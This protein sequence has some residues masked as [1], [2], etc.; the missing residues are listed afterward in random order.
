MYR[1]IMTVG[2]I[3]VNIEKLDIGLTPAELYDRLSLV[4][5]CSFLLES[6]V[7]SERTVSYSF[8]GF[9]PEYVVRCVKG[10]VEGG[11]D[12]GVARDD[13]IAY[14]NCLSSKDPINDS[15][16]PFL[17]GLVGYF[18][19]DFARF[20]EPSTRM[21]GASDF[22]D[23]E[24][25]MYRE[26]IIFDHSSFQAYYFSVD[27]A[28]R[29]KLLLAAGLPAAKDEP[30]R[31]GELV[32]T[33]SRERYE[34]VVSVCRERIAAGEAFQIVASRALSSKCSGNSL[35]LYR[36]LRELNPSPYMFYFDFDGRVVLGSSPETLVT[37]RKGEVI[38]FPIA[39]TRPLGIT[40]KEKRSYREEM[41]ADEKERAE[42]C[43]LVDLARNDVGKVCEIG[44][45]HV[46]VFMQVEEFSHVQHMVSKVQGTLEQGRTS[47]DAFCAVFPAGTVSGAP[48]PRAMEII[49]E[50][51]KSSR[52]PYAGAVGYISLNGNLDSAIAIRS[53]F[54]SNDHIYIQAGAGIVADSDPAKEYVEAEN[55]LKAVKKAIEAC[56]GRATA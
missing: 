54:I 4:S 42:H 21:T 41:L 52:G 30:F 20:I 33:M 26:G 29:L 1:I 55:K 36:S 27:G 50:L 32:P 45:V 6:A 47:F 37:V 35:D 23:F 39:G 46:P 38:T 25:G 18:S 14:L 19:Y 51:E 17:G 22:P 13:P 12:C 49:Q 24:L 48:K 8:M 5:K 31:T 34:K 43:M 9:Q 44:S 40:P 28:D 15:R 56:N 3:R 7:G 11:P 16:F 10:Q 53:A 2:D